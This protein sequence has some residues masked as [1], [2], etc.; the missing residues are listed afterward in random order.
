MNARRALGAALMVALV[1]AVVVVT[2]SRRVPSRA[3]DA[4]VHERQAGRYAFRY[5]G[6]QA[7]SLD[8][9]PTQSFSG[10]TRLSGTLVLT[11]LDATKT[12]LSF[13]RLQDTM[14]EIDGVSLLGDPEIRAME[15]SALVFERGSDGSVSRLWVDET[16][17]PIV[18]QLSRQLLLEIALTLR[19]GGRYE[20]IEQA[21]FGIA[22]STYARDANSLSRHRREYTELLAPPHEERAR[23]IDGE[24][25][26]TLS[27]GEIRTLEGTEHIVAGGL[28]VRTSISL[29]YLGA[30]E[31]ERVSL[32]G[33][34]PVDVG[35]PLASTGFEGQHLEQRVGDMTV[36]AMVDTIARFGAAASVPHHHDFLWQATGLLRLHPEA[37][38]SLR[39]LFLEEGAHTNARGLILDLLVQSRTPE[40]QAVVLELMRSGAATTD[41]H[42]GDY[43]QRLS[44]VEDPSAEIEGLLREHFEDPETRRAAA[45]AMGG[46]AFQLGERDEARAEGLLGRIRESLDGA[47]DEER[48]HLV[49]ALGNARRTEDVA[50]FAAFGDSDDRFTRLAV[51]DVLGKIHSEESRDALDHLLDRDD[52]LL[53][54]RALTSLGRQSLEDTHLERLSERVESRSLSVDS[55][56]ALARVLAARADSHPEATLR[57]LQAMTAQPI[58]DAA[59]RT[60]IFSLIQQ[61]E[62]SGG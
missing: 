30:G 24:L 49:R 42:L 6:T 61:L 50:R 1:V 18:Q 3:S 14:V 2:R 34:S 10:H 35:S 56:D 54:Q 60:R 48:S 22:R 4:D 53:Q 41:P 45:Y 28:D 16:S 15:G 38:G 13:E 17:P 8:L 52:A 27:E 21:P 26:A 11:P 33:R 36:D 47:P 62:Q 23:R 20:A 46:M 25:S 19:E 39:S 43:L 59:V 7:L 9:S 40:A 29:T 58:A 37:A 31:L 57:C 12:A 55:Y 5:E 44:F 51:A 32:A